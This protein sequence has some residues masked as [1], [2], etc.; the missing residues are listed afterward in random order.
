MFNS[1]YFCLLF[2]V[3]SNLI[4]LLNYITASSKFFNFLR[5]NRLGKVVFQRKDYP[6]IV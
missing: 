6:Y 3:N 4:N 2:I 1:K 5:V